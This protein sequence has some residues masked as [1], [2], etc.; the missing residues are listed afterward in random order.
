MNL[1]SSFYTN[2]IEY[3]GKLLIRG[4]NNGQSYLSR[5]NYSPKLYLPTKEQSKF[6][7]LDGTNLKPKQFDTISKAK[8]F[9]SEYSTIPEYK[10]FGMNRYNYQFIGDEYKDE[11]RWNKDY[12][13]IFT[14]DIETECE[15]GFPDIDTAKETII[16]IT[17]KNHSNKQILT[18]GT[19]DFISKKT[20]VTYVKC[21]NEKHMLLEFLKFWCKNHPD[22]VTG[23]NVKF[24]D[25]PYIMNRMRFIF[26]NDTINKMSPWNYVNADRI[27]LGK[28]N[29]QYWNIL[30]VSVLDYFDL[31]K[32]F[33]YV[34]QESYRLNYIAKVEL[35]ESKL[36]NPYETFKDF[37]TK[38][39]QKFV[40]Y[41]IQDVELVD[42]LEDKMKLIELCLTMAYEA[43]VNYTDVYSQVRCWDTII[44]NH[45][46]KK[47]IIIPPREDHDKDTQYEG[48]YVKDPQLGLHNW[49]VSFDLNSLYPHLIMQ[50]N[51]SPETLVGVQPKNM[52]VENYLNEKFNLQWA[53]DKNV[54]VAPNGS[55]YR[56][57]KQGFL[58][59]LMEKMYGDRVV[60]KKKTIEAKKEFQKTKDPIYKNEISRCNNIQMAKKIALNSAYGAI[61]NQYFRYFDVRIAEAITLGGQLSIRWVER[62][63]NKFMNKLLNTD[64]VNYVVASD[65][66]SIYLKLDKLVEKVCKDKS[67]QQ[68]TDFINK[69]AEDKIQKVIDDSFNN[70]A[71]YV[72]AYQQ[73]MIMKR[74]AIANKAIWV[75]KKRY[76]M[77]VFD[78]E[79]IRFDIPKLKIMG[80]E[81]VKSS[82]PEVCRGKI[83]D[84]IRVIM[85]DSED[86]LIKFVADFKEVFKTLSPEEVAFPRSCNYIDKYVDPNSIYKKGTPIHV[87]GALIYNH[88]ILK[89]KLQRKYPLIKDG[90]KIK[91]LMLRQPNTVKDTVISF[92]TKIPYEFDLHKYVDYETQFTKTFTD[93]L[94]FVL[95]SIGWKLEREAT[96]ESFFV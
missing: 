59:E 69:A 12:I 26:D 14:L 91:F 94:R 66:D 7:T 73:K 48:A 80:V 6:K 87:K 2:V 21:Q 55:M 81:A 18:W 11:I 63:V 51:L 49:I 8:H 16:C 22:I 60:F 57:D 53:K 37:Y 20:N 65:T 50:Y 25:I 24:F 79:G 3:K 39:Y 44:Y 95:D 31:Y 72:N 62:D 58:P 82:T 71:K 29:Q 54:T 4:V 90:D 46:L 52:G 43:K 19:G 70:L 30:G 92:A 10:I 89:N 13:K 42:K 84:A 38:D 76:M 27:K 96:L 74:E 32:K 78:E 23:W 86:A 47:N 28:K 9:Y 41:N 88:H 35:G 45:L 33:T 1:A 64:N 93:P 56:R 61:G 17:V 68:I 75:A 77:N 5:I 85:N 34:R 36:E 40:E 67:P 15:H 83:K